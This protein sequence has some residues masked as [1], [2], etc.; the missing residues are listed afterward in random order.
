M[1][2]V[3]MGTKADG[4]RV[5]IPVSGQG[6]RAHFT[7]QTA[8]GQTEALDVGAVK[9]HGVQLVV[10]GGSI[11]ACAYTLQGSNDGTNWFTISGAQIPCTVTINTVHLNV[12]V[13]WVRGSCN[14]TSADSV[15]VALHYVGM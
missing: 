13:G 2:I 3:M 5:P 1:N 4:T 9:D 14:S 8:A 15:S 6:I 10:I 7:A 12:P 11:G